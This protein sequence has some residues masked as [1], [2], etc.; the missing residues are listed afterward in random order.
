[1]CRNGWKPRTIALWT[2]PPSMLQAPISEARAKTR[3]RHY[4]CPN[5]GMPNGLRSYVVGSSADSARS[6]PIRI[7]ISSGFKLIFFQQ[8]LCS[9]AR[10]SLLRKAHSFSCLPRRQRMNFHQSWPPKGPSLSPLP[11]RRTAPL[12]I[13][14]FVFQ[15]KWSERPICFAILYPA[16]IKYK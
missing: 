13:I 11:A 2:A 1:M 8:S 16:M 6:P 9:I 3:C 4:R 12:A 10:V 14:R 7:S 5:N 15:M